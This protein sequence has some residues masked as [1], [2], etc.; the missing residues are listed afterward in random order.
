MSRRAGSSLL[1]SVEEELG[2]D[3]ENAEDVRQLP[4]PRDT[5]QPES[6]TTHPIISDTLFDNLESLLGSNDGNTNRT[7]TAGSGNPLLTVVDRSGVADME[8]VFCICSDAAK[9]DEQLLRTGL[10]PATFKQIETVFT[11]SVLDD[12]LAD[13]L[14]CK[15]TAQQYYSKLQSMTS[16]MFPDRVQVSPAAIYIL[17]TNFCYTASLQTIIE[18]IPTME[19]PSQ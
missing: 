18:G 6:G 3:T 4:T 8:I 5:P 16:S 2:I 17:H 13:N 15:T 11:F 7:R 12:F 10:L 19:G 1:R 14:E 9:K